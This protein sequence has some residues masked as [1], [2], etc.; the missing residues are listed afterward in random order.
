[1]MAFMAAI[2][3][4]WGIWGLGVLGFEC[5][6]FLEVLGFWCLV[7]LVA[8]GFRANYEIRI[9]ADLGWRVFGIAA[10]GLGFDFRV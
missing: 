6:G 3:G 7:V 8:L 1:M 9:R 4:F 10:V 2:L 5:V